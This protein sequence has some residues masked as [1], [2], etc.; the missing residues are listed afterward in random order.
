M[1]IETR[2]LAIFNFKDIITPTLMGRFTEAAILRAPLPA[3]IID[4]RSANMKI[5]AGTEM[6][7]DLLGGVE[8]KTLPRHYTRRIEETTLIAHVIDKPTI[9]E[10][11][12]F[13][14][15]IHGHTY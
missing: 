8:S 11:I 6:L 13:F 1:R 9:E 14:M 7:K 10:E 4:N 12:A 3:I 15:R 2:H 5:L